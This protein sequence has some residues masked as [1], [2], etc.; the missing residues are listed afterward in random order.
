MLCNASQ[1][2][3]VIN[4]YQQE[5]DMAM[6]N[7]ETTIMKCWGYVMM[8]PDNFTIID[9]RVI[10]QLLHGY[11]ISDYQLVIVIYND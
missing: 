2:N 6:Q 11:V 7:S 1:I 3:A 9:S 8:Q 4:H 5:T 10:K